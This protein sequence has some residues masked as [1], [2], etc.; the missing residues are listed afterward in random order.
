MRNLANAALVCAVGRVLT[1]HSP[2][3]VP[4]DSL[5]TALAGS[6]V[7]PVEAPSFTYDQPITALRRQSRHTESAKQQSLRAKARR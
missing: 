1:T 7:S 5:A 3:R 4:F 6:V 2:S